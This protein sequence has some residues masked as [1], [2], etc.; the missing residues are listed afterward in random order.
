ML[1]PLLCQTDP[2]TLNV[3]QGHAKGLLKGWHDDHETDSVPGFQRYGRQWFSVLT[4]ANKLTGRRFEWSVN[5]NAT[6]AWTPEEI[7]ANKAKLMKNLGRKEGRASGVS[8]FWRLQIN[9]EDRD[10]VHFHI[11]LLDG[12]SDDEKHIKEVFRWA[13]KPIGLD[14]LRISVE[15]IDKPHGYLAYVLK[16]RP[17]DR[18]K[19]VLFSKDLPRFSKA[20]VVRFP[21][22]V[23]WESLPPVSEKKKGGMARRFRRERARKYRYDKE[24]LKYRVEPGFIDHMSNL[25]GKGVSEVREIVKENLDFW[26]TQSECWSSHQSPDPSL[27]RRLDEADAELK[28]LLSR[29]HEEPSSTDDPSLIT[30]DEGVLS[31]AAD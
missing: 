5:I 26:Q 31:M 15:K 4:E 16:Y 27:K 12:F 28:R 14:N 23:E 25:T 6:G 10:K 2:A 22:P 30:E 13:A 17:Q 20:G 18:H 11:L 19:V 8:L 1:T 24:F 7:R 21:W 9:T 29:R 3:T